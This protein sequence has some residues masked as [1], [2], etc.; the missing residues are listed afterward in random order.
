MLGE[1]PYERYR[2]DPYLRLWLAVLAD[3]VRV[4]KEEPEPAL[5]ATDL[6]IEHYCWTVGYEAFWLLTYGPRLA[7]MLDEL[8]FRV[9][10]RQVADFGFL[11]ASKALRWQSFMRQRRVR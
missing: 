8:G 5:S 9:S 11:A 6:E 4:V 1:S 10:A 7:R 2:H 3:S